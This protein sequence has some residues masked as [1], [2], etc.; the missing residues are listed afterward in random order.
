YLTVFDALE[1][2][3]P[4]DQPER[5]II[6]RSFFGREILNVIAGEGAQRVE[7]HERHESWQRR[8]ER[9]RFAPV[10]LG[11][12]AQHITDTLDLAPP[13]DLLLDRGVMSLAWKGVPLVAASAWKP[14]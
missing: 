13:F 10:E 14:G 4:V 2:Q 5:T 6:E 11:H 3:L 9:L 7:R 1:A 12:L 8:L